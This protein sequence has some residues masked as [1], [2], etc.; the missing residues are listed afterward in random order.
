LSKIQSE[1][2]VFPTLVGNFAINKTTM[3]FL[4]D[5][6]PTKARVKRSSIGSMKDIDN[7]LVTQM[8]NYSDYETYSFPHGD[9]RIANR[10]LGYFFHFWPLGTMAKYDDDEFFEKKRNVLWLLDLK[11]RHPNYPVIY[12]SLIQYFKDND[13]QESWCT[14]MLKMGEHCPQTPM[15]LYEEM[16]YNEQKEEKTR[17]QITMM[18]GSKINDLHAA[19]PER[20]CFY[21]EEVMDILGVHVNNAIFDKKF[22]VAQQYIDT[23]NK[24]V[25]SENEDLT[26]NWRIKLL[27]AKTP[28][29][30][31]ILIPML[32]YS[33]VIGL[34]SFILWLIYKAGAW[35]W[36]LF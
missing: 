12:Y 25:G 31:K 35:I 9:L 15:A 3:K 4:K 20:K 23:V 22:D 8:Y 32:V 17:E 1:I 6:K 33:P 19:Y 34:I 26:Q 36:S 28:R 24:I 18:Y 10:E 11:S 29:W 14:T 21:M 5:S 16:Y 7:A 13:D 30:K 2:T 27:R